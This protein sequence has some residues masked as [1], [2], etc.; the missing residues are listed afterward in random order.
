L[1]PGFYTIVLTQFKGMALHVGLVFVVS[2]P[3]KI[4][5]R[6]HAQ[7]GIGA[8]AKGLFEAHGHVGW[9]PR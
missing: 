4:V 5:S 8:T 1:Y 6:L 9:D 3:G 2:G 7:S